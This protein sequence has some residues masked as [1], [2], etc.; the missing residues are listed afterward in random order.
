MNII[1]GLRD[2]LQLNRNLYKLDGTR[3]QKIR[4]KMVLKLLIT[5]SNIAASIENFMVGINYIAWRIFI[6]YLL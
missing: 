4:E 1:Q 5:R 6:N 3:L 2:Y